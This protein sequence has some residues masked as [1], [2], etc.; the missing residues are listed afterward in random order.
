MRTLSIKALSL[1]ITSDHSFAFVHLEPVHT[2]RSQR[3]LYQIAIKPSF[4]GYTISDLTRVGT[5]AGSFGV[6]AGVFAVFFF[7]DIPRLNRDVLQKIP[8][9]DKYYNNPIA[10]EDN[11]F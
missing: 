2:F 1:L 6:S 7:G 4:A 9:L 10:P 3:W 5:L 11:P 8:G